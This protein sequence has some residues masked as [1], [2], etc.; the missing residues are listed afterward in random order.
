MLRS[1]TFTA[2]PKYSG[3][4]YVIVQSTKSGT[5][6]EEKVNKYIENKIIYKDLTPELYSEC[7]HMTNL[8]I[9]FPTTRNLLFH[10]YHFSTLSPHGSLF[11]KYLCSVKLL[12][13]SKNQFQDVY[14]IFMYS[15]PVQHLA[16]NILEW[17]RK[18]RLS[19]S[20]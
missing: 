9:Q 3:Q 12:P 15:V 1:N 11:N 7:F 19:F 2:L 6:V 13:R 14:N 5:L 4:V 17:G 16:I 18:N 20:K 10:L 8:I